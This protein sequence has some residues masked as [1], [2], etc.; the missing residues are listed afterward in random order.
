MKCNLCPMPGTGLALSRRSSLIFVHSSPHQCP[1]AF[2]GVAAEKLGYP[3][4]IIF[5]ET[6]GSSMF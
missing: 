5:P 1:K 2:P 3:N 4:S 6:F